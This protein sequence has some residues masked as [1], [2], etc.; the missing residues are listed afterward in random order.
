M[1]CLSEVMVEM[2]QV[3]AITEVVRVVHKYKLIYN[4]CTRT[5][6]L[7]FKFISYLVIGSGVKFN[8]HLD[9]KP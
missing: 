3:H 8:R 7:I 9:F 4:E 6:Y 2:E 1:L 5:T